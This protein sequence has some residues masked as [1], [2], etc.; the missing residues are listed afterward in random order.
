MKKLIRCQMYIMFILILQWRWSK[1]FLSFFCAELKTGETY[2]FGRSPN[3]TEQF[4]EKDFSPSSSYMT[5]SFT[6]FQITRQQICSGSDV[7]AIIQDLSSNGTYLNRAKIGK[8]KFKVLAHNDVISLLN[9]DFEGKTVCF[10]HFLIST[11]CLLK[12]LTQHTP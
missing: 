11:S 4:L 7:Q 8:N 2:T 6:H 9:P 3:C 10:L 12:F 1:F 5:L